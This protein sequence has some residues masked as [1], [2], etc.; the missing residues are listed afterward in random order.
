MRY[1]SVRYYE[2]DNPYVGY[3]KPDASTTNA[4]NTEL[5][6]AYAAEGYTGRWV[7]AF[8]PGISEALSAGTF[9]PEASVYDAL[10][11][12]DY[13]ENTSW[14]TYYNYTS[15]VSAAIATR[16]ITPE[17]IDSKMESLIKDLAESTATQKVSSSSRFSENKQPSQKFTKS[18]LSAVG[19]GTSL[20]AEMVDGETT[21]VGEEEMFTFDTE[22]GASEPEGGADDYSY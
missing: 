5:A 12:A 17:M 14:A 13:E 1:N 3:P 7:D 2:G 15:K 16:Y 18:S 8:T 11:G 6:G 4:L 22:G 20:V 21:A 10:F 9:S 19:R